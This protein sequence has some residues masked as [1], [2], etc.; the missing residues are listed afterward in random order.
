M[1]LSWCHEYCTLSFRPPC[2]Y[3][4]KFYQK[5]KS[6]YTLP[7]KQ[8]RFRRSIEELIRD[9]ENP[10]NRFG[11]CASRLSTLSREVS[12]DLRRSNFY[13]NYL[14]LSSRT[15]SKECATD[16]DDLIFVESVPHHQ[17]D[18]NYSVKATSS[19]SFQSSLKGGRIFCCLY[20]VLI[21]SPITSRYIANLPKK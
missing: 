7:N 11:K 3:F 12:S 19:Q 6:A 16:T 13:R 17:A 15:T 10:N 8:K 4:S 1:F 18:S 21:E 20:I 5:I 9:L 14:I 2:Y